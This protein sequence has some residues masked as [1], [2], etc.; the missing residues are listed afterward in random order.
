MTAPAPHPA[1]PGQLASGLAEMG[2]GLSETQQARSL[3]Y[4]A[5]LDKW[6]RAFNLTAIRDPE[7]MV[8]RQLLDSLSILR[9]LRGDNI[10]DVGTG[11]GLPGVPLAIASP[12][13]HFT[14]LDTNGK[15][16]RFIHQ[17]LMELGLDNITVVHGRVEKF[18]PEAGFTTIVSRAFAALPKIIQLTAHL[19]VP[20]GLLLAMKGGVNEAE[21]QQAEQDGATIRIEPL[22]VPATEGSRHAILCSFPSESN[23]PMAER[24]AG[25]TFTGAD[26]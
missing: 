3:D 16:T 18:R 4:L 9:L 6:N 26:K 23:G 2:I 12:E 22:R 13:R 20:D 21:I 11:P 14:L 8:A 17:V 5:L 7:E 24:S 10:L 25:G 1:W 15:K 19:L